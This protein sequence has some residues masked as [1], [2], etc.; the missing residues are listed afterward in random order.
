MPLLATF[1]SL[2][3]HSG[4]ASDSK[5]RHV[6][7]IPV[8]KVTIFTLIHLLE[9]LVNRVIVHIEATCRRKLPF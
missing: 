5:A 2:G 3:E 4:T 1:Q 6:I 8:I 9:V 7:V